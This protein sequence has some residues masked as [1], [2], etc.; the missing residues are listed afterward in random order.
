RDRL[1]AELLA[2]QASFAISTMADYTP[3]ITLLTQVTDVA[4][5]VVAATGNFA[6]LAEAIIEGAT[7]VTGLSNGYC[8]LLVAEHEVVRI[9][10]EW[11]GRAAER[12]W[13][14]TR[15]LSGQAIREKR[16]IYVADVEHDPAY[17]AAKERMRAN[18]VVPLLDGK[19]KVIGALNLE[20]PQVDAF[21][22]RALKALERFATLAVVA[23][24]NRRLMRALQ[25]QQSETA[26]RIAEVTHLLGTPMLVLQERLRGLAEE[27]AR[28]A[29]A[30][31]IEEAAAFL[32]VMLNWLRAQVQATEGGEA[33]KAA[34]RERVDI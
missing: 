10:H 30:Q 18:L 6:A 9:E 29:T 13:S 8:A 5:G 20:S 1:V 7:R 23:L 28:G 27:G 25:Q 11:G 22:E 15:G 33:R 24:R 32:D 16:T 21:D 26:E 17:I 3:A 34:S 12:E 14:V 19:G 4:K 2:I 31:E